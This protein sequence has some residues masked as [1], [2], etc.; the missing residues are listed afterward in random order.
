MLEYPSKKIPQVL[1]VDA[2][3]TDKSLEKVVKTIQDS[4]T[5]Y[6]D[7]LPVSVEVQRY[8]NQ[9]FNYLTV[10]EVEGVRK[11]IVTLYNATSTEVKQISVIEIKTE[12]SA[13]Y[14][15]EMIT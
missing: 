15:K 13:T 9:I 14:S 6:R 10:V 12:T 3:K 7:I 2:M 11:Q 4:E 8:S 1:V 5:V